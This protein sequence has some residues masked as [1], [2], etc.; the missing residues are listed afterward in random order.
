[1]SALAQEMEK[2]RRMLLTMGAEV[3]QRV[4]GAVDA[5]V[6]HDLEVAEQ[7]RYGDDEIDQ[8]DLDIEA[9]CVEILALHQP[10]ASDLRVILATLRMNADLE[11]MAD[12]ARS[13]ARRAMKLENRT[14]VARPPV[15]A[16]M[17]RSVRSIVRDTMTALADL[18]EAQCE[19]I[20]AADKEIDVR[21]KAVFTW[22]ANEMQAR[23]E[24]AHAVIDI[25]SIVRA[26]ERIA[27]LS[28]NI[29]EAIIFSI[30]GTIV[31][32]SPVSE[33]ASG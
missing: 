20:R 25:L 12:L 29:A 3:D 1:M 31:R 21:Y 9:E 18:D 2:L 11:R 16:E 13:V 32:H 19:Q 7:V 24:A 33:S 17:A 10:V 23:G 5:L 8:M 27:D 28:V 26:L 14:P 30:E 4:A 22:A 15:L 6:R